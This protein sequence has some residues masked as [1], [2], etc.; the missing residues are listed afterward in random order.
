MEN[1][2]FKFCT[3]CGAKMPENAKF[4]TACGAPF[5][6]GNNI[7]ENIPRK[8]EDSLGRK[9]NQVKD[10]NENRKNVGLSPEEI[11][12]E[13]NI[14]YYREWFTKIK[15]GKK[16]KINWASFWLNLYHAAYRNVWKEWFKAT[17]VYLIISWAALLIGSVICLVMMEATGGKIFIGSFVIS[18]IMGIVYLVKQI[19]FSIKFNKI[20]CDHVE[21][22]IKKGDIKTDLS[23]S[24]TVIISTIFLAISMCT[25]MITSSAAPIAM[26]VTTVSMSLEQ[27]EV[28]TEEQ[29][30]EDFA[31]ITESETITAETNT[32]PVI[33]DLKTGTYIYDDGN[34]IYSTAVV[35]EDINGLRIDISAMGYGGHEQGMASG[36]LEAVDDE[37][38]SCLDESGFGSFILI[39][40]EEGFAIIS[41]PAEGMEMMFSNIDGNYVYESSEVEETTEGNF[42]EEESYYEPEYIPGESLLM[43]VVN[44]SEYITLREEPDVSSNEVCKIPLGAYVEA[45][46][47]TGTGFK[48][49]IYTEPQA[50][51]VPLEYQ[52]YVLS[53]YLAAA[54]N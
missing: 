33:A 8:V 40:T 17:G 36:Y 50:T 22:K 13:K 12:V 25:G 19:M 2:E 30:E 4:C 46:D 9:T 48:Y 42:A 45:T 52:G 39:Q 5:G 54:Y 10:G 49:V 24:R 29:M 15:N 31:T 51:G 27:E 53:E 23:I 41:A 3:K 11:I 6:G 47:D 35:S 7:T 21:Q 18:V 43:E 26:L 16:S 34:S 44:C 38:Y 32:L 37:E 28:Y 1:Q 20:Y 14:E